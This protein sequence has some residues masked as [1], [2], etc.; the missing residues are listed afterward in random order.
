MQPRPERWCLAQSLLISNHNLSNLSH[1]GTGNRWSHTMQQKTLPTPWFELNGALGR[2]DLSAWISGL[3][4]TLG[5]AL[6]GPTALANALATASEQVALL[7][8]TYLAF[9]ATVLLIQRHMRLALTATSF[10]KPVSLVTSG[11]F[12]YSRN[13]IYLA[14]LV[15]L[16]TLAVLSP[17][18]A[19]V[20]ITF[21][22]TLMTNTVIRKEERDLETCFGQ[23][24][25]DY[26]AATPRWFVF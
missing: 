10:G 23:A 6:I 12:Q 8:G 14:F 24:F 18:A 15:P 7:L 19:T 20:A 9:L 21:Y 26:I 5:L 17:L 22:V 1:F 3:A 13:P 2:I 25:T 11:I 4:Y 16:A